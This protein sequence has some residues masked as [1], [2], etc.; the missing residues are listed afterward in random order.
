MCHAMAFLK[1]NLNNVKIKCRFNFHKHRDV[2]GEII[3]KPCANT[4]FAQWTG[5]FVSRL[6]VSAPFSDTLET[7][8]VLR[9]C[10]PAQSMLIALIL[11]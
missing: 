11:I 5:N 10:K 3:I 1:D 2:D 9:R 6:L 7:N 8:L 4:V